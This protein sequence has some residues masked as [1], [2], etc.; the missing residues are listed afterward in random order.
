[1]AKAK[2]TEESLF[3]PLIGNNKRLAKS[4]EKILSG[5][6]IVPCVDAVGATTYLN[7]QDVREALHIESSLGQWQIC[8]TNI[9]YIRQYDDV[10]EPFHILGNC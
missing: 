2:L 7:R 8:S 5:D 3:R 1:M 9:N 6:P 10:V 4:L